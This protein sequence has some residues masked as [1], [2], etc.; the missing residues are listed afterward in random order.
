MAVVSAVLAGSTPLSVE[1]L[2]NASAENLGALYPSAVSV[3][4][5]VHRRSSTACCVLPGSESPDR[6]LVQLARLC[7]CI[8]P[9]EHHK[10]FP[11]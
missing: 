2:S 6:E 3:E 7:L 1:V 4:G 11:T 8:S 5:F 9:S 10:I